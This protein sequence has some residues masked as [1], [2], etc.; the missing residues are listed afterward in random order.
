MSHSIKKTENQAE[1]E[2]ALS[3]FLKKKRFGAFS[4]IEFAVVLT[5]VAVVV[6]GF[7]AFNVSD[8]KNIQ[9]DTTNTRMAK[10]NKAFEKFVLE[11]K[12]MP[13]P[14]SITLTKR[15]SITG[16]VDYGDEAGDPGECTNAGT[17]KTSDSTHDLVYG[18][19]PVRALGLPSSLAND[20]YG[21]KLIYIIDKGYTDASTFA[22]EDGV[23]T[24]N[25]YSG[26]TLKAAAS[27]AMFLI[28]SYGANKSGS[29][30]Q[31]STK[32]NKLSLDADEAQN[33][34]T[35]NTLT[36]TA[37]FSNNFVKRTERSS[38][39]FD[40][41]LFYKSRTDFLISAKAEFL[42]NTNITAGAKSVQC[43]FDGSIA[44]I[45]A[46]STPVASATGATRTCDDAANGFDTSDTIT[47][48]CTG[49]V[50]TVT[51][52]T[53]CDCNSGYTETSGVC[54]VA[55]LSCDGYIVVGTKRVH[56]LDAGTTLSCSGQTTDFDYLVVGGGGKGGKGKASTAQCSFNEAGGGGGGGKV[57]FKTN[58][59][60]AVPA[61]ASQI[62]SFSITVTVGGSRQ[63][64]VVSGGGLNII[65]LAGG[66][67]IDYDNYSSHTDVSGSNLGGNKSSSLTYHQHG[68]GYSNSDSFG[69]GGGRGSGSYA[70]SDASSTRGASGSGGISRTLGGI[71][72][73]Y[74][75]GG[76]G[77]GSTGADSSAYSNCYGNP[78]YSAGNG[79]GGGGGNGAKNSAAQSGAANT[80]GGGGGGSP[81]STAPGNGGS[82]KVILSYPDW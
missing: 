18:A 80:G 59:T 31:N 36:N 76:G 73:T 77:G 63:N 19:I 58:S 45:L 75:G 47:Y 82:G 30:G 71:T 34:I 33:S 37:V 39:K 50:I 6:S 52:G 54:G 9:M 1:K 5:V 51:G 15:S 29:F 35:I 57:I 21:E 55:P 3:S 44:G 4:L 38:S 20:A 56:I 66:D 62:P 79:G 70:A 40:D 11:N 16:S 67:G 81:R 7:I 48:D 8:K 64:S 10:V 42:V 27:D 17:Y 53:A 41:V 28:M 46:D 72:A 69:G 2:I 14:A 78:T 68:K 60:D 23:I 74:G 32:Q 65:A 61:L 22:T 25:D 49:G 13:C 43:V 24:I 26:S 12:R